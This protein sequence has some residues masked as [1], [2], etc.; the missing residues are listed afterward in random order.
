VD[1]WEET[2]DRAALAAA[3]WVIVRVSDLAR[4]LKNREISA[5]TEEG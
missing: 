5:T 3:S 2:E 1:E 4:I